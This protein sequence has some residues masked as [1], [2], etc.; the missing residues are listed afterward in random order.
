MK[1][2]IVGLPNVG[3]STL[4]NALT[5]KQVDAANYPFCTIDPNVGVVAVPDER[6][7]KLAEI[8]KSAQIIPAV[9]EFVDIA[10][11]VKNAHKGEGL[12]NQFLAH[13]REVDAIVEVLRDFQD[14]NVV[15]VEGS[16]DPERDKDIIHLEL[17]MADLQTVS[18]RLGGVK[19]E[20][21][22]GDK[23]ALKKLEIINLIKENLE[24]GKLASEVELS[25][26]E[27]E[28]IKDLSLLT[29][30][31]IIFVLNIGEESKSVTPSFSSDQSG[32]KAGVT[33]IKIDAKLEA[34]LAQLEGEELKEYMKELG[35]TRTGLDQLIK[36]SYD[37]L[38]LITFLTS[39]EKETRAW[40]VTRGAKAPQAAGVI[41]TDFEQGFIRAEVVNYDD[42]IQHNGWHGIKETGK[43]HLEGKEY[44]I[45]DGDVVYFRV[46][47]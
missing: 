46:G 40:T 44:E 1:V 43:M 8:S 41:H 29:M 35:L 47:A 23:E 31:P 3:K 14:E 28:L 30:K 7:Q 21:K 39:G 25:E 12:G 10:G 2:G 6:L 15:H 13:I 5:K 33:T 45:K 11:L 24:Q 22:S 37:K 42:F 19:I 4:F 9:V 26:E 38:N 18:K 17:I 20:A 27:K 34:E 16:V 32:L 36:V